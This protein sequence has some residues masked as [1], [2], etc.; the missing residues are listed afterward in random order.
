MSEVRAATDESILLGVVEQYF[1]RSDAGRADV[2]DL[3]TEDVQ[4]FFPK[5]GIATGKDAFRELGAGLLSSLRELV[6]DLSDFKYVVG[7]NTVVVE[8]TTRGT[9]RSG[10]RW[11]GGETPGGRFCSTFEFR[12]GLIARMHIYLDPDYTS[13]DR[14]RFL[15]GT[16]RRW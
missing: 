8:G 9:A 5:F 2:F 3:F 7:R 13:L 11:E 6:H 10:D 16:D 14:E 4:I 1:I 12:D 15:W